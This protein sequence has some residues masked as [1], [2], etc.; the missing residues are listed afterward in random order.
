ML[1]QYKQIEVMAHS[2]FTDIVTSSHILHKRSPGSGKLR[3][4]FKDQTYMDIWLSEAGKYSYHWEQ[5]AKRGLVHRHDNAPDHP[6]II[7]FPKH[8]HN[9]DEQNIHPSYLSDHPLA[10]VRE[11]LEFARRLM[12]EDG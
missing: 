4:H 1:T 2:E 8:F 6:E 7:T 12:I 9:G 10:A 5:R 3:L 11:F